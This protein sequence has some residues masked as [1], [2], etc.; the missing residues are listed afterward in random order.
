MR[1]LSTVVRTR[2][3]ELRG[4][5]ELQPVLEKV[6][7]KPYSLM[8]SGQLR[9]LPQDQG[10]EAILALGFDRENLNRTLILF[11]VARQKVRH[12]PQPRMRWRG[13][14]RRLYVRR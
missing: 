12:C 3:D 14:G 6:G 2:M 7:K 4:K 10:Q 8:I 5:A 13:H 1:E 11:V 9:Q